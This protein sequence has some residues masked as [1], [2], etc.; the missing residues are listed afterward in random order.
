VLFRSFF[1]DLVHDEQAQAHALAD[2][3]GGKE[4]IED[5]RKNCGKEPYHH[6]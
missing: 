6:G 1:D 4:W 3:L 5:A 2:I